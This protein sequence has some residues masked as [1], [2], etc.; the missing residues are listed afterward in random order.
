MRSFRSLGVLV[1]ATLSLTGCGTSEAPAQELPQGLTVL[2]AQ[3]G[4]VSLAYRSADVVIYMQ[5]NRGGATPEPYQN[6]PDMPRFEIDTLFTDEAG[7][8]FYTR[9]GGDGWV[10]PSWVDRLAQQDEI[11]PPVES[12]AV[13]Y[14]LATEAAAVMRSSIEAQVGGEL[15]AALDDEIEALLDFADNATSL[16]GEQLE[17]LNGHNAELDHPTVELPETL[18][19]AGD[20]VYGTPGSCG[21]CVYS[22]S[23]GAYYYMRVG[24]KGIW[25]S[26]GAGEHSA[27]SLFRWTGSWLRVHD[28]TNH[29]AAG[30]TMNQKC[31]FQYYD[32]TVTNDW[33]TNVYQGYCSGDYNWH[34]DGSNGGHNC[35]DDTRVQ[36]YN[37]YYGDPLGQSGTFARWCD[38]RDTFWDISVGPGDQNG[39]PN[40]DTSSD[41]GVG[42]RISTGGGGGGS[43]DEGGD[44]GT[45]DTIQLEQ[46]Y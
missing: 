41:R 34:S 2:E 14:R 26:F 24:K 28:A 3:P 29:G 15:A 19:G 16:Y 13:L 46:A 32:T 12:N 38:G 8:A 45:I 33:F 7:F 18:S 9:M 25:Y 22:S 39:S 35:H 1:A 27:T 30:S 10:D 4:S 23:I 44:D 20:V 31:L 37:F 11:V 43:W 40:C 6:T 21:S 42:S 5:A 36:L 17:V